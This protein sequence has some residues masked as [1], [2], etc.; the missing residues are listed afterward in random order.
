M[1]RAFIF[2]VIFACFFASQGLFARYITTSITKIANE[3]W[4]FVVYVDHTGAIN[5][6]STTDNE[7][8]PYMWYVLYDGNNTN[9]KLSMYSN[10][11]AAYLTGKTVALSSTSDTCNIGGRDGL[12]IGRIALW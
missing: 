10:A 8:T 3:E 1:K 4:G 9:A 11:L 2:T 6:C 5:N 7:E 12:E